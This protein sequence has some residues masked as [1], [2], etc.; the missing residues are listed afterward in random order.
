MYEAK[1]IT[2][3][4]VFIYHFLK[5]T[6]RFHC[7]MTAILRIDVTD[8]LQRIKEMRAEGHKVSFIAYLCKATAKTIEENP[9][10]N[11]RL[12][13][14]L[15]GRKLEASFDHISCG[16]LVAREAPDGEEVL[17][18]LILKNPNEMSVEEIHRSIKENKA[19]PLEELDSYKKLQK[20]RT[21]PRFLIPL[22]HFFFRSNPKHTDQSF[23]TYGLSS[24]MQP[25][26]VILGGHTPSNQTTFFPTSLRDE[27]LAINGKPEVRKVLVVG[28]S[29]D[30]FVVDGMDVQRA[31]HTIRKYLEDPQ[32]LLN[33]D[34]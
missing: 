17:L 7:P 22:I 28:F 13:H 20:V 12:Y 30:H 15:F 2:N 21:L 5:R 9:R 4:R 18:Q 32:T 16:L 3:N 26:S 33:S 24:V 14:T 11:H 31:T 19:T 23:S 25:D 29:T 1:P 10:L 6:Q 8:T 34:E 27:V